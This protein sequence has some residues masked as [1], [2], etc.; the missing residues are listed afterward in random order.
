MAW[1]VRYSVTQAACQSVSHAVTQS[2]NKSVSQPASH[3]VS[4][5]LSQLPSQ[6]SVM[7][8]TCVST[9]PFRFTTSKF[10]SMSTSPHACYMP[11]LVTFFAPHT[12]I[13]QRHLNYASVRR[14]DTPARHV[15]QCIGYLEHCGTPW[16]VTVEGEHSCFAFRS[17]RFRSRPSIDYCNTFFLD[18]TPCQWAVGLRILHKTQHPHLQGLA[19]P[20]SLR[21][22]QNKRVIVVL[23]SH[24]GHMQ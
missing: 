20:T 2:V 1:S 21:K 3:S 17:L 7:Y 16:I 8:V 6:Q 11:I 9:I 4:Q 10:V 22:P 23:P 13:M 19:S 24:S 18:L 14:W 5:S 15:I 12:K